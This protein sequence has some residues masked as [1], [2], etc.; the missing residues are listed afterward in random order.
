MYSTDF[1][2]TTRDKAI[3]ILGDFNAGNTLWGR[4]INQ[5]NKM[6]IALEELIQRH[7]LYVA[8]DLD[9]IYQHSPNC[10]NSGKSTIDF[11][12]SY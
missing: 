2:K 1:R 4:H 12:L 3:I 8:T 11:T 7:G 9:H 6:G 5:N 10:H